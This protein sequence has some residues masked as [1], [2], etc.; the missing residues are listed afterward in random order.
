MPLQYHPFKLNDL[1]DI[2]AFDGYLHNL[3]L[4]GG[5]D[6]RNLTEPQALLRENALI[7]RL[8]LKSAAD[9]RAA[10]GVLQP[11]GLDADSRVT[12]G[13]EQ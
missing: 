10:S 12:H 11:E 13:R 3:R 1:V 6:C 8:K 2:P 4:E 5:L 7:S 9:K